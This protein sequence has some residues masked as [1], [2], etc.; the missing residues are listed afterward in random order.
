MNMSFRWFN[1]GI[2]ATKIW[3]CPLPGAAFTRLIYFKPSHHS[4]LLSRVHNPMMTNTTLMCQHYL[5]EWYGD[6]T[7]SWLSVLSIVFRCGFVDILTIILQE[8]LVK[9]VGTNFKIGDLV[10]AKMKSYPM[11]P[12]KIVIHPTGGKGTSSK[13]P[14][15]YVF[16]FG[17]SNY[18][19]ILEENILHHSEEVLKSYSNKKS[20]NL[21]RAIDEIIKENSKKSGDVESGTDE[22]S[23]SELPGPSIFTVTSTI[24]RKSK[25]KKYESADKQH[26]A[27]ANKNA[28]NHLANTHKKVNNKYYTDKPKLSDVR[29]LSDVTFI[30]KNQEFKMEEDSSVAE[31]NREATNRL[32]TNPLTPSIPP[33]VFKT[34]GFIGLGEMGTRLV[35]NL[36]AYEHKVTVWNRTATKC[37]EVERLGARRVDTPKQVVTDCDIIFC[38][39][40]G[41]EAVKAV[42]FENSGVLNGFEN[43]TR[44]S[45]AYVE[46]TTLDPV[47]AEEICEAVRHKGGK[48]LEAP[49]S[50]SK[51]HAASG[52]MVML[53]AGDFET[54]NNCGSAFYAFSS[55]AYY[56]SG[57]VGVGSKMNLL[58]SMYMGTSYAALAEV[59]ALAGRF[60]IDE[61][62]VLEFLNT[63]FLFNCP[64]ILNKGLDMVRR[65]F[66]KS[67]T[68]K[69]QQKDMSMAVELGDSCQQSIYLATAANQLYKRTMQLKP[70]DDIDVGAVYLA[71]Q[72]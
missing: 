71:T 51:V 26:I 62:M 72:P 44:G 33:P 61:R 39:V 11:W 16:F 47:T 25:K 1:F 54:F 32:L 65:N 46:L 17:T 38:C 43:T 45:K 42:I 27:E 56:L 24:K 37:A 60:G 41:P 31:Y 59:L 58:I 30:E 15:H 23:D 19:W 53:A 5:L 4:Y 40:S 14:H 36:L 67:N 13:K 48:Y 7:L 20:V 3:N 34:I 21:T 70:T 63:N 68:L 64:V 69:Y 52:R 12:A 55:N 28:Q 29:R 66:P 22:E 2:G 10:W 50:G 49:M 6:V 8:K 9:M 57:I 18:A 35:K